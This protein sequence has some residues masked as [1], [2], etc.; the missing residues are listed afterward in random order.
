VTA[1][2]DSWTDADTALAWSAADTSQ[3]TSKR[4]ELT[5]PA[6][7]TPMLDATVEPDDEYDDLRPSVFRWLGSLLVVGLFLWSVIAL[8]VF[9]LIAVASW[10][11]WCIEG[12]LARVLS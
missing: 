1:P 8:A 10:A 2:D 6:S 4:C 11:W 7:L 9:G 12:I 5:G 3:V